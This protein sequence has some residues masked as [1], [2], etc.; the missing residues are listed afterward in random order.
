MAILT[1]RGRDLVTCFAIGAILM[2]ALL[3]VRFESKPAPRSTFFL[4]LVG[5]SDCVLTHNGREL[6][7]FRPDADGFCR[8]ASIPPRP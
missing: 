1:T 4:P 2:T 6:I 8:A 7:R 5:D 3:W